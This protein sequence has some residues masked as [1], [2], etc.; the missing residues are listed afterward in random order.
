MQNKP[1]ARTVLRTLVPYPAVFVPNR[2]GGFDV[3]FPNFSEAQA[4]GLNLGGAM[5]AAQE[6]LTSQIYLA[7][8]TGG[9][10]EEPSDPENLIRDDEEP[11]GTRVIMVEPDR[12][13]IMRRFGLVKKPER[14]APTGERY[15][16]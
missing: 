8:K 14:T 16:P 3:Y 9:E 10:L 7:L 13:W 4:T 2:Y 12:D 15:R 11:T 5:E 1:D 6:E